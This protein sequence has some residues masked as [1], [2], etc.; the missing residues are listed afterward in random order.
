MALLLFLASSPMSGPHEKNNTT[1]NTSWYFFEEL[2][3]WLIMSRTI[4]WTRCSDKL[5]NMTHK[6]TP[7]R[8]M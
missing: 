3:T 6:W 5:S 4:F 8:S 1:E 2:N 7:V